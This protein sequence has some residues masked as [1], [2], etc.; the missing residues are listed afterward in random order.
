MGGGNCIPQAPVIT[1]YI[2]KVN[3]RVGLSIVSYQLSIVSYQLSI[4][5][6]Q[7]SIVSYRVYTYTLIST[8]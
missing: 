6:Y 2:F 7:L 3:P 1:N 5:S 4:V 8:N